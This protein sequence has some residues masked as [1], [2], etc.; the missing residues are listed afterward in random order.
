MASMVEIVHYQRNHQLHSDQHLPLHLRQLIQMQ[1]L[2]SLAGVMEAILWQQVRHT[3]CLPL[4]LPSLRNGAARSLALHIRL[5]VQ[6]LELLRKLRLL[7]Q[8]QQ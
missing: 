2:T 4:A 1:P 8:A 5:L 7:L 6:P 3:Q